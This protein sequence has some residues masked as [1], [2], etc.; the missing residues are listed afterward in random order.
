M[1]G[2]FLVTGGA[3]RRGW[4]GGAQGR[5][6]T[7]DTRIFSPLLY[8]LSYLGEVRRERGATYQQRAPLASAVNVRRE[9]S[10]PGRCTQH[11]KPNGLLLRPTSSKLESKE[12]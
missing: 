4:K 6:R 1:A 12:T 3:A 8:Q 11:L 9:N 2:D 7:A 10:F 5:N